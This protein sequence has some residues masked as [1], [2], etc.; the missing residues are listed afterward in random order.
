M[1]T[2]SHR[3]DDKGR[4]TSPNPQSTIR[5]PQLLLVVVS[6]AVLAGIPF[7]LGKYFE[8]KSPDPFDSG[9][10]VYSAHHVLSGARIGY[11]EKPSAQ[12]GTLL[13]NMLGVTLSGFNE[14]GSKVLQGLF[15]AAAFAFLFITIR[16]L[17]GSLAAVL[18]VAVASI[19]LSAPLIAKFGNVKEQFMIAFMIAGVCCFVWYHLTGKWWWVVLTGTLLIWGPMFKQTGMSAIG[20]V[21]L[22]TLIQPVPH[23]SGWK[24]A[25]KEVLLLVAGACITLVPILGW[26]MSMKT[27]VHYWPYSFILEPALSA[28]GV[29]VGKGAVG[30]PEQPTAAAKP[31]KEAPRGL[32]LKLLPGYVSNSWAALDPAARKQVSLRV[33]RYYGLLILPIVLALGAIAARAVI[34]VRGRRA[35]AAVPVEQDSGRFVL[36]FGLWWFFD[37]AFVWISPHTYE[38]YFLPLNASGAV[39]GGY[40]AGVYAHRLQ[41]DRDKTRWVV[42]G[43]LGA[44]LMLILSWHIFFGI[45]KSPYSGL[46]YQDQY[47]RPSRDR[48]YRQTWKKVAANGEYPWIQVGKYIQNRSQPTDKIYVWGWVPGIYVQAQR[49]SPAPKAF[50]GT[51]HTLPPKDLAARVQELLDAFAKEPPKFIVD[52]QNRHFPWDRPPLQLWPTIANGSALLKN[53]P[54]NENQAWATVFRTYGVQAADLTKQGFLLADKADAVQRYNAA[55]AKMLGQAVEPAEA[56][57]YEAMRPFRDYVMKNYVIAETFGAQVVFRRK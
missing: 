37:M 47:G 50:E 4:A 56:Q 20:A 15:Q 27:P 57:R 24:K 18:S 23:H 36:L 46:A 21:G 14:T 38:Q 32:L 39:L 30:D 40:V 48:G 54:D 31:D 9:C 28:V 7:L 13:M 2:A 43:L 19:F 45:T 6:L 26:Y 16:R 42:L 49:L 22:F 1:S 34:L 17:Y 10:Y 41:T 35:K 12:A 55:Y 25:G 52:T 11:D 8:L 33:L 51:M 5:N 29:D 44:L 53:L 3:R